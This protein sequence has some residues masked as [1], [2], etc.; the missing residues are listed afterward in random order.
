MWFWKLPWDELELKYTTKGFYLEHL[1][2]LRLKVFECTCLRR[3]VWLKVSECTC[4]KKISAVCPKTV[5]IHSPLCFLFIWFEEKSFLSFNAMRDYGFSLTHTFQ[6]Q[7]LFSGV[8]YSLSFILYILLFIFV[9]VKKISMDK[10]GVN[11]H[12]IWSYKYKKFKG[13]HRKIK[14]L[15]F[16]HSWSYFPFKSPW[17]PIPF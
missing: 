6:L 9:L 10:F 17:H 14:T 5:F 16:E 11:V 4:P 12:V 7:T 15:N 13:W 8:Y 3:L 1:N 2:I